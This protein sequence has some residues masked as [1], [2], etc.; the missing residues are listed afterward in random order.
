MEEK[1]NENKRICPECAETAIGSRI[2]YCDG[3]KK[4]L[5][6][7]EQVEI[8]KVIYNKIS[9][10]KDLEFTIPDI[11]VGKVWKSEPYIYCKECG[12]K[13]INRILRSG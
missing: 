6:I 8:M 11:L 13:N 7:G 3:C 10:A 5:E 9:I 1:H 12:E 4:L 2:T